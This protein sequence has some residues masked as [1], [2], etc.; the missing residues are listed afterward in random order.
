MTKPATKT[1][2]RRSGIV[3][4]AAVSAPQ[5]V[6]GDLVPLLAGCVTK[7]VAQQADPQDWLIARS[8]TA[9]TASESPLGPSQTTM[10]T[11]AVPRFLIS[12]STASQNFA[13]A[14][15]FARLPAGQPSKAPQ[16][17]HSPGTLTG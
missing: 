4:L 8:H 17:T 3:S 2:N 6:F 15:G 16:V 11:S 14:H 7:G 1:A 5:H 12:V 10:H 13:K 9:L